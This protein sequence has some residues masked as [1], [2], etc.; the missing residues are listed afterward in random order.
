MSFIL[1]ALRK[2][3]HERDR[4]ILPGI[5]DAPKAHTGRHT[6]RWIIGLGAALFVI[7]SVAL[8]VLLM[9]DPRPTSPRVVPVEGVASAPRSVTAPQVSPLLAAAASP[10]TGAVRPLSEEVVAGARST[11]YTDVPPTPSVR[12]VAPARATAPPPAARPVP[13]PDPSTA[14]L[15]TRRQ[16]PAALASALP[17]ISVDLHVYSAVAA[18]RFM[19]I[20]GQRAGEG[21][22]IAGGIV[23]EKIT[24]DGAIA[25]FRGTRFLLTRE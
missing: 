14:G 17:P 8:V 16:L 22:T 19:V 11:P 24:P 6:L 21:A 18:Q 15:P 25:V 13:E 23:I 4:R 1:D 3:E 2:A 12:A 9:R 5:V 10:S 20:S 7:N